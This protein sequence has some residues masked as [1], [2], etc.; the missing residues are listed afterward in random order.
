[1][2]NTQFP[3]E[4]WGQGL[5]PVSHWDKKKKSWMDC[6]LA[7]YL[8][9]WCIMGMRLSA[10]LNM[11]PCE[12]K[13]SSRRE[14]GGLRLSP[15][16]RI[17]TQP[18]CTLLQFSTPYTH[19]HILDLRPCSRAGIHPTVGCKGILLFEDIIV[20]TECSVNT[21]FIAQCLQMFL[22]C[23]WWL[24]ILRR[25]KCLCSKLLCDASRTRASGFLPNLHCSVSTEM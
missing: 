13:G 16:I 3:R 6:T 1:M 9:G 12:G 18:F 23:Y 8:A 11:W 22:T 25:L 15:P 20:F 10:R 7:G 5:F 2:S 4:H 24:N 19:T 21:T 17:W 14:G